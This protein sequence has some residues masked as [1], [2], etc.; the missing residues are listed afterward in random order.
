MSPLGRQRSIAVL[1]IA[2]L[3]GVATLLLGA[4]GFENHRA[5]REHAHANLGSELDR[6]S[7]VL[8]LSLE[9]PLWNFDRLGV[10]DL[11]DGVMDNRDVLAV[12]VRQPDVS[13]ARGVA[14]YARARD[15]A[16]GPRPAP[17]DTAAPAG[18]APAGGA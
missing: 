4:L 2:A 8:A 14:V 13:S 3:V 11:L 17:P 12:V 1:V 9:L 5:L 7:N 15:R 10:N 18:T 6:T 16:R